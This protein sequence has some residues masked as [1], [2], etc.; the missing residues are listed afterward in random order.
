MSAPETGETDFVDLTLDERFGY[1][2]KT[3]VRHQV[4]S[5]RVK[6]EEDDSVKKIDP[7]KNCWEEIDWH[8]KQMEEQQDIGEDFTNDGKLNYS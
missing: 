5:Y 6:S 1:S 4:D 7:D 8:R 2:R 3:P